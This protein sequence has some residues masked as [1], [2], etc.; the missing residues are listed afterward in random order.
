MFTSAPYRLASF[1]AAFVLIA[2]LALP[3]LETATR[4]VL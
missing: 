3:M 1:A 4:I 2:L